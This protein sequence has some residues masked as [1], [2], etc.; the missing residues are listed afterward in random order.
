MIPNL[1]EEFGIMAKNNLVCCRYNQT[2]YFITVIIFL[3]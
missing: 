1:M 3:N 2:H